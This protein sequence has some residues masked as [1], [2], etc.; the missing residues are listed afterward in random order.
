MLDLR[1]RGWVLEPHR[2]HC[3]VPLSKNINPILVLVQPRKTCAFITERLL[4]GRKE[5]NQT[6]IFLIGQIVS[7]T[8]SIDYLANL[9]GNTLSGS[10]G[11]GQQN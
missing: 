2:R 7:I 9:K 5:S 1:P 11:N 3:L 10:F 8:F 4:K 6:Q